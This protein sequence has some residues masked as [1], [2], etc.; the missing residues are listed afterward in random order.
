MGAWG[1][2]LYA[3]DTTCDVRNTYMKFLQEQISNDEAYKKILE[4]FSE[5]LDDEDEAPLF[6]FAL[7][8][9]QWKAG[10]L[11]SDVKANALAWIEK[12]GGMALWEES[13]RGDAGWQK[14]LNKLRAKL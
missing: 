11:R 7:A 10:R 6:W 1:S 3:N 12:G 5:Y 9:T 8:D 4:K 2:G 14:T 13:A